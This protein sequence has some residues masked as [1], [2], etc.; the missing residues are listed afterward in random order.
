MCVCVCA[1]GGG[2]YS[3]IAKT[4]TWASEHNVVLPDPRLFFLDIARW[5]ILQY[6]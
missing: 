2:V 1:W 6:N 4:L 3:L 5:N